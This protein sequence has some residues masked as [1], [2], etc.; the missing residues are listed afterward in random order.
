MLNSRY[1][2][3]KKIGEGS[4]GIVYKY[5]DEKPKPLGIKPKVQEVKKEIQE[6]SKVTEIPIFQTPDVIEDTKSKENYVAIKKLKPGR[7]I[8]RE[9]KNR[10]MRGHTFPM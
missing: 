2:K 10:Q 3:V 8:Y 6:E 7:V 1:R 9:N 4:Y 5:I